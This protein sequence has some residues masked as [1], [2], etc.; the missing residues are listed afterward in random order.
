MAVLE[1]GINLGLKNLV[2]IKYY[3]SDNAISSK[4]RAK[5]LEGLEDFLSEVYADKLNVISFSNFRIVCYHKIVQLSREDVK[6]TQ[7]LLVFAIIEKETNPDFVKEHLKEI[8]SLF[9]K[10]YDLNEIFL[11]DAWAFKDFEHQANLVLGDLRL[12]IEDRIGSLFG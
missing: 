8:S 6:N 11:K 1:V 3:P 5:F 4:I 12:K 7:P 9:L 2:E 10:K